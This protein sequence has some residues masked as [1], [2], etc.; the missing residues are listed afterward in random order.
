M[1]RSFWSIGG[2]AALATAALLLVANPGWAQHRGGGGF[3]GYHG[4]YYGGNGWD[5]GWGGNGFRNEGFWPGYAFGSGWVTP[6][7]QNYGYNYG[8]YFPQ[9]YYYGDPT[10]LNGGYADGLN[11]LPISPTTALIAVRVPADAEVLV[12]GAKT[13]QKGTN[14]LFASP[15]LE[16][17]KNYTY[18]LKAHWTQNGKE[19]NETR[20]IG[21]QAGQ[22][23]RVDFTVPEARSDQSG[24]P[25]PKGTA[26]EAPSGA[27]SGT[28][29]PV[30]PDK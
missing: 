22:R 3:G 28:P 13:E 21:V 2:A 11:A 29:P 9:N 8:T 5:G 27:P 24:N 1:R 12:M 26:P 19:F 25:T 16:A 4:G 30:P 15:A 6:Y 7:A 10:Q 14:R 23:A 18:E 17:G 20:S